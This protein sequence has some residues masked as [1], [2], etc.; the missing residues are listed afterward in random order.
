MPNSSIDYVYAWPFLSMHCDGQ[1]IVKLAMLAIAVV[2]VYAAS[3]MLRGT[4]AFNDMLQ[5]ESK[6]AKA[7]ECDRRRVDLGKTSGRAM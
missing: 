3:L 7:G 5:S 1:A 6:S 2:M 4:P